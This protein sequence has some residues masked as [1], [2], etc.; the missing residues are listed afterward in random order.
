P[1]S[2]GRCSGLCLWEFAPFASPVRSRLDPHLHSTLA[3]DAPGHARCVVREAIA[4]VRAKQN[5]AAVAAEA[6]EKVGDRGLG[7]GFGCVAGEYP[8]DGP[9][10]ED[11]L[12]DGFTPAGERDRGAEIV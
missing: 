11:Q 8:V 1:E 2:K 5:D 6:A 12:H 3:A 9:F 4:A 7:G 10:A